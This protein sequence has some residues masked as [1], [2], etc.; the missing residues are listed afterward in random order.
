MPTG[1]TNDQFAWSL[2]FATNL[3]IAWPKDRTIHNRLDMVCQCVEVR[4]HTLVYP[5]VSLC[6]AVLGRRIP[7]VICACLLFHA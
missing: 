1:M 2:K 5:L 6:L 7:L 3:A 4:A